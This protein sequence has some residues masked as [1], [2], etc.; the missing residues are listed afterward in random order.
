MLKFMIMIFVMSIDVDL[1]NVLLWVRPS[2]YFI[3]IDG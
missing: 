1:M 2:N 3:V